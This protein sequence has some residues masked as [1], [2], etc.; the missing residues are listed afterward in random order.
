ME[1]IQQC[2]E[3][4][5]R[6]GIPGDFIETGVWRGGAC[7]FMRGILKAYADTS[8]KVWVADSFQG[9]P[10]PDTSR[11][12]ADAGDKLFT[13]GGLA[14]GVDQVKH[15]FERYGLLDDQ[16]RFLTGWFKDS[17][18]TAPIEQVAV[19]RLDG[20]LYESTMDALTALWPKVSVGGFVIVDDYGAIEA[21]KQATDEFRAAESIADELVQIDWTGYYWRR[22]GT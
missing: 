7:I 17:L 16:V 2:A 6:D 14:V 11:Y 22:S 21:C 1:N 15:N 3:Q 9:L 13:M 18:P 8:R 20:D 10:P 5:I 12:P 19:A 4:V